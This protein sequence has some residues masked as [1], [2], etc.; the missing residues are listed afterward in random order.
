LLLLKNTFEKAKTLAKD[1]KLAAELEKAIAEND[2]AKVKSLLGE[3]DSIPSR[4]VEGQNI[5]RGSSKE[6]SLAKKHLKEYEQGEIYKI[7]KMNIPNEAKIKMIADLQRKNKAYIEGSIENLKFNKSDIRKS[8]QEYNGE[9]TFE[10]YKVDKEG[11]INTPNA[12]LRNEDT[13]YVMLSEIAEQLGAKKGGIYPEIKG[14]ITI[15]S[16]LPYCISC[17]GVIQ[18]FSKMFPNVKINLIDNLKY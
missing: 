18:D 1:E 5:Y 17:Q 9:Q 13:E 12:W 14:E 15:V 8:G 16:E 7:N 4:L 3:T 6:Y 2:V 10:A 11:G